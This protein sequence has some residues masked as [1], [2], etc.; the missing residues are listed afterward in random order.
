MLARIQ[1]CPPFS[2][3]EL[4]DTVAPSSFPGMGTKPN[5][6]KEFLQNISSRLP[7]ELVEFG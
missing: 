2:I 1:P 3:K 7:H 5:S 6:A 4:R